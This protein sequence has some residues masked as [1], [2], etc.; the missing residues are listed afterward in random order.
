[1][2]NTSDRFIRLQ[3]SGFSLLPD[4]MKLANGVAKRLGNLLLRS[5]YE[6]QVLRY[7]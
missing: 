5:R 1:M 2:E 7:F 3:V 4:G 6:D